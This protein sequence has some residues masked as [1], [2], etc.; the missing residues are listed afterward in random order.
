MGTYRI[1]VLM[2]NLR[3]DL[4]YFNNSRVYRSCV[5]FLIDQKEYVSSGA[6]IRSSKNISLIDRCLCDACNYY[7][8]GEKRNLFYNV[9]KH[10]DEYKKET[11]GNIFG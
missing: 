10:D 6:I 1:F 9:C 11:V 3:K 8:I 7:I 2:Y 5:F 4:L